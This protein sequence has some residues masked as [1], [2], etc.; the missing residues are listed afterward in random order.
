[1]AYCI[2]SFSGDLPTCL[3]NILA[4]HT[5]VRIVAIRGISSIQNVDYSV[6]IGE[7]GRLLRF[8]RKN[9]INKI[10][11]L[12]GLRRP[13][14]SKIKYD[15][16]G[17]LWAWRLRKVFRQGDNSLLE[18]IVQ[19]FADEG[20]TVCSLQDVDMAQK[21]MFLNAS[22]KTKIQPSTTQHWDI[23]KGV[24]IIKLLSHMDI[25]QAV[26][27]QQGLVLGI[28]TIEGTDSLLSRISF[29]SRKGEAGT[30]IKIPKVNQSYKIDMPT[31]GL[32][33]V[34]QAHKVGLGGIA[35]DFKNCIVLNKELVLKKLDEYG[36]FLVN[37]NVG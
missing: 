27:V 28:E 12:G 2:L 10:F 8:L 26:V 15:F 24:A 11:I 4:K 29:V 3:N 9:K 1:M 14:F 31:I 34:E 5:L 33:T 25:G 22:N 37:T 35:L 20:I 21:G 6:G 18:T 7:V 23:Q 13:E 36:M 19:L 17:L 32:Q 16:M 30:L